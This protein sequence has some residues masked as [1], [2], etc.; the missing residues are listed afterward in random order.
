MEAEVEVEGKWGV[1]G[2]ERGA[3]LRAANQEQ[4]STRM[5]M[6][7]RYLILPLICHNYVTH[8]TT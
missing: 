3:T 1:E 7:Y 4:Q 6:G 5:S 2:E 8:I